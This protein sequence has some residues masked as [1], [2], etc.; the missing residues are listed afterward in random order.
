MTVASDKFEAEARPVIDALETA[1]RTLESAGGEILRVHRS[2]RLAIRLMDRVSEPTHELEVENIDLEH[3]IKTILE[4]LDPYLHGIEVSLQVDNAANSIRTS[5]ID[6]LRIL[7]N[8]IKNAAEALSHSKKEKKIEI[9]VFADGEDKVGISVADNGPGLPEEMRDDPFCP[10]VRSRKGKEH[11]FGL[12]SIKEETVLLHCDIKLASTSE[13][14]TSFLLTLPRDP[15]GALVYKRPE[16]ESELHAVIKRILHDVRNGLAGAQALAAKMEMDLSD[17]GF[18]ANIGLAVVILETVL[19]ADANKRN[20]VPKENITLVFQEIA[21]I[22]SKKHVM[23]IDDEPV[24]RE[25]FECSL[26]EL[27]TKSFKVA[28]R[29]DEIREALAA[30]PEDELDDVVLITDNQMP[31]M[32]GKELARELRRKYPGI[33]ILLFSGSNERVDGIKENPFNGS[34]KK[35]FDARDLLIVLNGL[36]PQTQK[37]SKLSTSPATFMP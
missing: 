23:V 26:N 12:P 30:V 9:K 18:P 3:S 16:S 24:V 34:L 33:K 25:Y 22:L 31:E 10:Q 20:P 5:E 35:P 28:S 27:E 14:G 36:F 11:G 4:M 15:K 8:L 29:I 2:I 1:D 6:L 19:R 21:E 13:E 7:G 32:D 37:P 17:S